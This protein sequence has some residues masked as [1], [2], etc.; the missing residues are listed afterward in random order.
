MYLYN[1]NILEHANKLVVTEA[2]FRIRFTEDHSNTYLPVQS[3]GL[4][5]LFLGLIIVNT[6][7]YHYGNSYFCICILQNLQTM[8]HSQLI[9]DVTEWLDNNSAGVSNNSTP[10][11]GC[12]TGLLE[13]AT[14]NDI[15]NNNISGPKPS[16]NLNQ[17]VEEALKGM[18][19]S[20]TQQNV[21]VFSISEPFSLAQNDLSLSNSTQNSVMTESQHITINTSK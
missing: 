6:I 1:K 11:S 14:N 7:F 10:V 13:N 21:P 2:N 19:E 5:M 17:L 9:E 12:V 16:L 18:Q 3:F 20:V 8:D 15:S 4:V